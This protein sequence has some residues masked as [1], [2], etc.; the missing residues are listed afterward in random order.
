MD[1]KIQRLMKTLRQ[2]VDEHSWKSYFG[3]IIYDLDIL[4]KPLHIGYLRKSFLIDAYVSFAN[5]L[6]R[7]YEVD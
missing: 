6:L 5:K 2:F 7:L 1:R 3:I 4:Y